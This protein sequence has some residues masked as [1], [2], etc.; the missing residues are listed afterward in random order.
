MV[1]VKKKLAEKALHSALK[2]RK[3][4]DITLYTPIDAFDLAEKM[5][6]E[7]RFVELGSI[8]GIYHSDD[9]SNSKILLSALRPPGRKMFSCAHEI[10]HYKFSHGSKIDELDNNKR[11][12]SYDDKNEY[13][14]DSFA[15]FLLMP[16][17][18]IQKTLMRRNLDVDSLTPEEVYSLSNYFKVGYTTLLN[19]LA[20]SLEMISINKAKEFMGKS[21]KKIR[22]AIVGDT[23]KSDV[24]VLGSYWD[25]TTIDIRT[26]DYLIGSSK[27]E[28]ESLPADRIETSEDRSIIQILKPGISK[29]TDDAIEMETICRVSKKNFKGR[30][31][32]RHEREIDNCD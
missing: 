29:I 26:G 21:L 16:K 3:E 14:A 28:V 24:F 12:N 8:E 19:H 4:Q 10:A 18:A 20:Y 32:F 2:L 27:L 23:V 7:V 1:P 11:K 6:I 17:T 13:L 25:G 9:E 15:G 22:S 31:I 5:N 30:S